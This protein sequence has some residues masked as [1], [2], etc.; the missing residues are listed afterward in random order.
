[1]N[2]ISI[3]AL[4]PDDDVEAAEWLEALE[5]TIRARAYCLGAEVTGFEEQVCELLDVKHSIGVSSGTDALLLALGAAGVTRD[6]EVIVP[7]YSFFASASTVAL[8]GAR[9]RFVDVEPDTLTLDMEAVASAITP[10]TRA[11]M[12]VHLYGQ[13]TRQ[14]DRLMEL[15]RERGLGVVED[16]A[17]VFGVRYQGQSLGSFGV[18]GTFSFYPTKNLAA[19][20][21]AGMF[22]TNDDDVAARVRAL[23]VHGDAGGYRHELL[24]WNA[25]MDGFQA[26]VLSVR[27]RRL[28]DIQAVRERN[29]L[30][31][32]DAIEASGLAD[33]VRPLARTEDSEH[34]WHQFVVRVPE[35]DRVRAALLEQG[36]QSGVYYPSTL[37][38]QPAFAHLG[39]RDGEFP[40]AEQAARE[41]LALPVHHRLE[42]EDPERVVAALKRALS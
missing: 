19:P 22:I 18:G 31:Y 34:G 17:Q 21:D 12:P 39:H 26:A 3:V 1:M 9:P 14:L 36:V 28:P 13:A 8:L 29:A 6:E 42:P 15:C 5:R 32:G 33:R 38:S 27:L 40:V 10:R 35:R 7:A 23:R 25:R 16:A 30:R 37:P 11:V 41:V 2:T 20:G 4:G 24:G